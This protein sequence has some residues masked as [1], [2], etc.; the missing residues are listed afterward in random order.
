MSNLLDPAGADGRRGAGALKQTATTE[1]M[2]AGE[3]LMVLGLVNE[4]SNRFLVN[5]RL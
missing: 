1:Q 2:A 3:I 5:G 4:G